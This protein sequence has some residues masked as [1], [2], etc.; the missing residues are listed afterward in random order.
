MKKIL[1]ICGV[2]LCLGIVS[3]VQAESFITILKPGSANIEGMYS[4]RFKE[5]TGNFNIKT[6]KTFYYGWIK[7]KLGIIPEIGVDKETEGFVGIDIN[8]LKKWQ[9]QENCP[10]IV[11]KGIFNTG[12]SFGLIP[13]LKEDAKLEEIIKKSKGDLLITILSAGWE[14]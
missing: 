11:K 9:E 12:I 10:A 13:Y 3:S 5:F 2:V 4:F 1:A 14:F 7:G 6:Q 8:P